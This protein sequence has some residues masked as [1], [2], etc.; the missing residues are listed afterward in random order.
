[1]EFLDDASRI[2][3]DGTKSH[4][5]VFVFS[6]DGKKGALISQ[7]FLNMNPEK[8][9]L[10]FFFGESNFTADE[11]LIFLDARRTPSSI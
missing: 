5:V 6:G 8:E 11:K 4:Y 1:M 10:P 7:D 2:P 9:I 3:I